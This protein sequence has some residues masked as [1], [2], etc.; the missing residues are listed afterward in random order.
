MSTLPPPPAVLTLAGSD[1]SGGAGIQADILTLA[2]LG[3]HP[4]S[5]ITAVT[6]QDTVGVDDFMV[7]EADWVNDQA[8]FLLEDIPVAAFKIGML[9]S[10]ENVAVVAQLLADY[11]DIPVVLDPVL[12]SGG[13]NELAD[14]DLAGALRDMLIPQVSILT[15]NTIEARRLASNDPDED[16]E[17]SLE[18]CATRLLALGCQHLLITGTHDNTREV[19]NTLYGHGG[20]Q[21]SKVIRADR[22]ERLPHSYHGSGCTLASAIA[23]MLAS[24][25][26]MPEAVREAQDYTYQTLLNGMRL[27]MG[28]FIPDRLFWARA[29]A[30]EEERSGHDKA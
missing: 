26:Q 19:V 14:E 22:W 24:G 2:S 11:P 29:D 28:Q 21:G 12:A 9:G 3:C 30:E 20:M 5:V 16:E 15:P 18:Q 17:L 13:G 6:V 27:G 7:M 23:G 1:P 8:R 10:V 4:L 25:L